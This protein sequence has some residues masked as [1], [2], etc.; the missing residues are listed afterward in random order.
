MDLYP[1]VKFMT[2]LRSRVVVKII[3]FDITESFLSVG[4]RRCSRDRIRCI[5][6]P[7]LE[8]KTKSAI[9]YNETIYGG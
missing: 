7:I 9:R 4:V 1:F 3:R 6:S 2:M 5:V 8:T